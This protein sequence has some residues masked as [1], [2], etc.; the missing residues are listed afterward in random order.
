MFLEA[1][2]VFAGEAAGV[3]GRALQV[4]DPLI[5]QRWVKAGAEVAGDQPTVIA[6]VP[7]QVWPG[8]AHLCLTS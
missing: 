5:P 4:G 1:V 2:G 7:W 6:Q 8:R 3:L